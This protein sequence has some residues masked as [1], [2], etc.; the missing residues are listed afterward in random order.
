[1]GTE[2]D[3]FELPGLRVETPS[4]LVDPGAVGVELP[5][6]FSPG[7]VGDFPSGEVVV[8]PPGGQQRRD[9]ILEDRMKH[10]KTLVGDPGPVESS[11]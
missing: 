7:L 5:P 11:L 8:V 1:M 9:R 6:G 2:R 3:L 10:P 4:Q